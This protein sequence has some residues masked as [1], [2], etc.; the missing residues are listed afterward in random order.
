[1]NDQRL[2][3]DD[4]DHARMTLL[5]AAAGVLAKRRPNIPD[6]FVV[7][8]FGLAVPEDLERYSA[9]ALAGI[10]ERSWA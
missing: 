1:M 10:A 2:P 9:D 8:L 5:D 7:K 6:D 3:R 4:A